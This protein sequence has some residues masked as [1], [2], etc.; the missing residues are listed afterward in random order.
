MDRGIFRI[1]PYFCMTQNFLAHTMLKYRKIIKY[2]AVVVMT[3][4]M[5]GAAEMTGERE[6]LFPEMAAL[7]IGLWIVD[8]RVWRATSLQTVSLMTLCAVAGLCITRY[9]PLTHPANL[10]LAF[11]FAAACLVVSAT[12]LIPVISACMLPVLLG[13]GSWVYPVSVC[14]FSCVVVAGSK[15][16]ELCGIRKRMDAVRSGKTSGM[17]VRRWLILLFFVAATVVIAFG[18]GFPYMIIPPLVVT[19]A[20]MAASTAGFRYRPVQIFAMLVSAAVVGSAVRFFGCEMLHMPQYIAAIIIA[21]SLLAIFE[22]A[23]KYFAPAGAMAFIPML[24]PGEMLVWLPV[25]AA[26]GAAIFITVAMVVFMRCYKWSHAQL[27]F[28]LVPAAVKPHLARP[29][30]KTFHTQR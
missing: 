11:A 7:T 1:V 3:A 19:F 8:K 27:I 12:T 15:G 5:C 22:K 9:S 21:G 25:Q 29:K 24:V 30:K 23:G 2:A 10:C 28:C 16:M 20:E 13:S 26:L 4:V 17:D 18:L 14:L 6:M